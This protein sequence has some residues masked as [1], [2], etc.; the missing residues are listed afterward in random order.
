MASGSA[1]NTYKVLHMK[2]GGLIQS[3]VQHNFCGRH[4]DLVNRGGVNEGA[5]RLQ[6]ATNT[7]SD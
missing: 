2:Y 3:H 1:V 5:N 7:I 4:C 6:T